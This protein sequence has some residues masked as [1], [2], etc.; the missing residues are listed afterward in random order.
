[1]HHPARYSSHPSR[2]A[3]HLILEALASGSFPMAQDRF[4]HEIY[5][6]EPKV[7]A[8]LPLNNFHVPKKLQRAMRRDVFEV[9]CD[10]DFD[11][12]IH[13]CASRSPTWI[14]RPIINAY[15]IL[16]EQ[17]HAH[18][19]ECWQNEQLVGG[20]YG[21]A[22]G[23]AFFGESMVS[24]QRDASK[25]ALVHLAARLIAGRFT[26]LDAQFMTEHLRQFGAKDINAASFKTRLAHAQKLKAD[27]Y[28]LPDR[29]SGVRA[30]QEIGQ[31]S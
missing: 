1:M 19:V 22:L 26:L 20:L 11:Q 6:V 7:R 9:R 17:G 24:R 3:A 23:A 12:M 14:N 10:R 8:V 28:R 13:L 31:M 16:H 25:I 29:L 27:F 18:S 30:L 5:L 15:S 2:S 21:I 4:S